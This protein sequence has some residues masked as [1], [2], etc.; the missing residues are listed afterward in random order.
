MSASRSRRGVFALHGALI[1]MAAITAGSSAAPAQPF[2]GPAFRKG[3]WH[4]ERVIERN[5]ATDATAILMR[6]EMTRC[7][8][9]TLSMRA[10]FSSPNVGS[11]HSVKPQKIGNQYI[12]P[13]R[14]DYMGPVRT[15][16]T[17]ESDTAY[18]EVNALSI[19]DM[20]RTDTVVARRVG[21]CGKDE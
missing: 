15:E 18:T 1:V 4:F 19:G 10:T 17:V 11:C 20:P 6:R 8:D 9:P 7:V 2:D 16:I 14:C 13:M 21:D 5:P 12:F 3:M